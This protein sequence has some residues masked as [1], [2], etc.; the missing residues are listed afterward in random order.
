MN[1]NKFQ[2]KKQIKTKRNKESF[3]WKWQFWLNWVTK[4]KKNWKHKNTLHKKSENE[5]DNFEKKYKF[6]IFKKLKQ[7]KQRI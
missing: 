4:A 5:L 2:R 3:N 7:N 6:Y 1:K